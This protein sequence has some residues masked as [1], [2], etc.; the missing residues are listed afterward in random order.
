MRKELDDKLVK[1]YPK[2]FK[3]RNADMKETAMCWGFDH[4]DGWFW[5]IDN[6]CE[7]IQG[8]IDRND[9]PQVVATQVKEKFGSLR[10]Y[11]EGGN[12]LIDGMVWLVEDMSYNIC[13]ICGSTKN[14]GVTS[15]WIKTVCKDCVKE[16]D[17]KNWEEY[18]DK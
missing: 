11:Y 1:K 12:D 7:S 14:V 17:I 4:D 8:Y 2:I 10:F 16:K 5:L 18:E 13:E 15:G 9:V 6:L 3:D